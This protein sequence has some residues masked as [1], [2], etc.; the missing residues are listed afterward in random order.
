MYALED[1]VYFR[2]LLDNVRQ[3]VFLLD[4]IGFSGHS[5]VRIPSRALIEVAE[6]LN[7]STFPCFLCL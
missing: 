7:L 4:F 1:K 5:G 3:G 6:M 2:Q